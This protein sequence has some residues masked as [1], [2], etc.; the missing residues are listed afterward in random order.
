MPLLEVADSMSYDRSTMILTVLLREFHYSKSGD[1]Y[2]HV[3]VT[4]PETPDTAFQEEIE[5][6]LCLGVLGSCWWNGCAVFAR[7]DV[8]TSLA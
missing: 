5:V 7:R 8:C 1:P 6:R 3:S 4:L 2:H